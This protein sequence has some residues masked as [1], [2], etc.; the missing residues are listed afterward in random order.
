VES[1]QQSLDAKTAELASVQ[2]KMD[3]AAVAAESAQQQLQAKVSCSLQALV[4]K[5]VSCCW[6]AW[7]DPTS[8]LHEQMRVLT[9]NLGSLLLPL[10]PSAGV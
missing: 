9:L 3:E 8:M 4:G 7:P 5:P 10:T 6:Q 1:L 2:R